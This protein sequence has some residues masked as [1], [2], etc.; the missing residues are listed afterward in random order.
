MKVAAQLLATLPHFGQSPM[1]G[2]LTAREDLGIDP[3]C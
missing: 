2:P 1:A 3:Y